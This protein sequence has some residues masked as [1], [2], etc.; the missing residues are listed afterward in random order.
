MLDLKRKRDRRGLLQLDACLQ[1]LEDAHERDERHVS[2]ELA[3]RVGA[4]VPGVVPGM[5]IRSA[6]DRVLSAQ[7]PYVHGAEHSETEHAVTLMPAAGHAPGH[8]IMPS[9]GHQAMLDADGARELTNRIR[10]AT[11]HVCLLLLEAH[12]GRAWVALGYRTWDEYVHRELGLS[13]TRSYEFLDQA[14]VIRAIMAAANLCGAPDISAYAAAQIKRHLPEVIE[15]IRLRLEEGSGQSA[16]RLVG[17]VIDQKRADISERDGRRQAGLPL[18]LRRPDPAVV[19]L[20][21]AGIEWLF[22]VIEL[23]SNMPP[24]PVALARIGDHASRQPP[25][26]DRAAEWLTELAAA[27]SGGGVAP[28]R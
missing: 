4:H 5:R 11:S 14:H 12:D 3:M 2:K 15:T 13:R 20:S 25:S 16:Q 1:D 26:T 8:A 17:E 23:L 19:E 9:G 10:M 28:Q 27:L 7:E 18:R 6:I 24:V 21:P 22:E